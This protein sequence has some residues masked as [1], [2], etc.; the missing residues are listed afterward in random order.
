MAPACRFFWAS[1][2][3]FDAPHL[4]LWPLCLSVLLFLLRAWVAPSLVVW[5]PSPCCPSPHPPP[6]LFRAPFVSCFLWF[7][8]PGVFLFSPP[9]ASGFFIFI[10]RPLCLWLSLVSSRGRPGPWRCVLLFCLPPASRLFVSSC[11]VGCSLMVVAPPPLFPC[12][13]VFVA[14][15]SFFLCPAA[16]CRL[17]WFPA[18]GALGRGAVACLFCWPPASLLS[19]RSPLMCRASPL[20]ALWWLLPPPPPLLSRCFRCRRSV[21]LFLFLLL[22]HSAPPFS[23]SPLPLAFSGF[24]PRFFSSPPSRLAGRSRFFR[25]CRPAPGCSLVFAAP[26]APP[27]FCVSRFSPLPLGARFFCFVPRPRCLRLFPSSG[28]RCPGP[29]R[30]ALFVSRAAGCG[31]LCFASICVVSS[32]PAVRGAS[33]AVPGVVSSAGGWLGSCAVLCWVF[34]CCFCCALLSCVAAFS[35]GF[36]FFLRCSLPF[37]GAP[38]CFLSRALLVRC[39]AGVPAALLSVRCSLAPAALAGVLFCCL[40]C[41]CVCC[42]AWLSSVVSWWVLMGPGV[43][44]RWCAVVCP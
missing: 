43:V 8:A 7:P 31:V 23:L 10:V 38:G 2:A 26:P 40:L 44:F 30:C 13:A 28:P 4:F 1:R 18:P 16:V 21:L 33:C 24:R 39:G 9:P 14:A 20:S 19:V 12:L 32:F 5:L 34:L 6:F 27:P 11:P 17:C 42:W 35:A 22:F 25:V 36:S 3:C 15:S 41:L 37:R 29:W